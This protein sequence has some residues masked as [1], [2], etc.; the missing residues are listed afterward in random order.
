MYRSMRRTMA[1]GAFL[2]M[3]MATTWVVSASPIAHAASTLMVTTTTDPNTCTKST[4]SLRCAINQ[5]NTDQSGDTITFT[6]PHSD[7][8]CLGSVCTIQPPSSFFPLLNLTANNTIINGYTQPGARPN[9]NPLSAGD[10]AILTIRLDGGKAPLQMNNV[11]SGSGDT[12]KGLDLTNFNTA[13]MTSGT[14]HVTVQGNFIG[15]APDGS[16]GVLNTNGVQDNTNGGGLT[17]GGTNPADRNVIS[18]NF[19]GVSLGNGDTFQGN[20]V[21]LNA[22]GNTPIDNLLKGEIPGDGILAGSN[23]LIG[24]TTSG[25]GNVISG[26]A[27]GI[28]ESGNSNVIEGNLVGTDVTGRV[29]IGN[30]EGITFTS[31]NSTIGGT[32]A[33]ARNIVSGNFN[34]G[35]DMGEGS[36]NV[37]EGNYIGTDVTG[38]VAV[39]N[40]GANGATPQ[41]SAGLLLSTSVQNASNNTI[42]GTTSAARNVISGN[43]FNGVQIAVT[44]TRGGGTGNTE[45]N[46]LEGNFIGLDATGTKAL[47]NGTNGVF[48][49]S[50]QGSSSQ[51]ILNNRIKGNI[52]A[53]NG[54]SGILVGSSA[55]DTAVHTPISQNSM[56]ANGGL[57]IDLAPQGIVNCN[58]NPP[59]PNDYTP[60]PVITQATTTQV[61]GTAPA[62][63]KVEVFIASNEPNALRHGEGQTFLGSVLVNGSGKWNLPL[64]VGQVARGQLVTATTTR[65][66]PAETSEFAANVAIQ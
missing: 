47:G 42:G 44:Q 3:V 66:S 40:G 61:S 53:H 11:V 49:A 28:R 63:S 17:V 1:I 30:E 4:F 19:T 20:I 10:N 60:C 56:F 25:A 26:N 8:G 54:K 29:A 16:T 18:G 7:S 12:I 15:I 13:I 22:A 35:I 39:A 45:N 38:T 57:G 41:N 48:I 46:L 37:V 62:N 58:T 43:A 52:I 27:S 32:V 64:A 59:G 14:G 23:T 50:E 2:L 65:G 21:G 36:G 31:S 5:A 33:A 24:G 34:F 55:S 9:T 6:I 51:Q